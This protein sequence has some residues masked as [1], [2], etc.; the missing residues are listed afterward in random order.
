MAAAVDLGLLVVGEINP[1]IIVA[2]AHAQPRFG[3][4]ERYVRAIRLA[5]GSSSV[6]AACGATR[7]GLRTAFVGVVGDDLFGR[8]MLD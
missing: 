4:A 6:I 5:V 7:L 2:G 3:Q 8:F 1:D